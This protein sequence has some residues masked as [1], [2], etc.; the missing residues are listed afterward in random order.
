MRLYADAAALAAYPSGDTV[1]AE[2]VDVALRVA[3][4]TV[5]RLLVGRVYDTD[6]AGLPTDADVAQAL[7]DAVCAI[8]VEATATGVLSAGGTERWDSVGIG[9]VSLSGRTTAP[10]ALSVAGVPVPPVAVVHLCDVGT[11]FVRVR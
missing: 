4:H 10:G 1:P 8:A 11:V 7:S 3:S 2:S 5:D 9:S 6:T